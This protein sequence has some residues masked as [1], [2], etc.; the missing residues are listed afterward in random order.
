MKSEAFNFSGKLV[1]F[2]GV[3]GSG[4]RERM[5]HTACYGDGKIVHVCDSE[6][7]NTTAYNYLRH[8]TPEETTKRVTIYPFPSKTFDKRTLIEY[9]D[10]LGMDENTTLVID[11]AERLCEGRIAGVLYYLKAFAERTGVATLT[12]IQAPSDGRLI[13]ETIIP[14]RNV[15][16]DRV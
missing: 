12:T 15:R 2:Y 7:R 5:I 14:H 16:V 10:K 8:L 9:L 1:T 3:A 4:A 6:E 13:I 11:S